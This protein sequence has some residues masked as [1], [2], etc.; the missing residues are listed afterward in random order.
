MYKLSIQEL[1]E[2]LDS[3]G[4][5]KEVV[6]GNK[7][8]HRIDT[9]EILDE[10]FT[11]I[12]YF[13]KKADKDTLFFA[14]G[15]TFKQEYLEEAV[16]LGV[17]YYIGEDAFEIDGV[18]GFIVNDIRKAMALV[19]K[20]FYKKPDEKLKIIGVTGTKGKTT[21]AY[22]IKDI[23]EKSFPHQVGF[24]SSEENS[25]DGHTSEE[26]LLT[27]PE[28]F[29]LF[30]MLAEGVRNGLKYFV[31]EVSSQAY[32]MRRVDG[33]TFEIGIFLNFSPDHIGGEEHPT[34]EDY[35]YNKRLLLL[36]SRHLFIFNDLPHL[37]LIKEENVSRAE[38]LTTFGY[39]H[40]NSDYTLV[41][42]GYTNTSF[43]VESQEDP[44]DV[45]GEYEL[46][47]S[48]DF[49]Q[50]NAMVA[51]LVAKKIGVARQSLQ[52]GLDHTHVPGRMEKTNLPNG[53]LVYIDYAHNYVSLK[54]LLQY[55]KRRY[56][57]RKLRTVIG[58]PG[59]RSYTRIEGMG[60]VFS[61]IGEEAILTADDPNFRS[62]QDIAE[63]I[64]SYITGDIKVSIIP[65]REEAVNYGLES[66]ESDEILI[67]AGKGT[68][69]YMI[70]NGERAPYTGDYQ[71][72]QAFINE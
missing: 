18:T 15:S 41:N 72:L 48:G 6:V 36:N 49:N 71:L 16:R 42:L 64:A 32:K 13:S 63:E 60:K 52:V 33:I 46:E 8:K 31:M 43:K 26:S 65:D 66:L 62:A 20:T 5:I 67:L 9:P 59:S 22:F 45:A 19:A 69:D 14:K 24:I 27:T 40:N 11:H 44:F 21:T 39:R 70:V 61:E 29:E 30:Y 4:L 23:L 7:W 57:E 56:P 17:R 37:S 1:Q 10:T 47:M 28:P 12:S 53:A 25:Y 3:Q 55:L 68:E 38:S 50:L 2:L 54:A 58:A 34:M 35:F 51:I